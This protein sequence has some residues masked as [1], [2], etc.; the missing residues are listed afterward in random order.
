MQTLYP[1]LLKKQINIEIYHFIEIYQK[2]NKY[3]NRNS[4]KLQTLYPNLSKKQINIEIY[5]HYRNISYTPYKNYFIEIETQINYKYFIQISKKTNKYRNLLLYRNRN[6]DK[7][8]TLYPN[9]PK[10]QINI[11]IY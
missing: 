8:Q 11:E 10:K 7:L 3:R 6:S 2:T 4:D 1:N 5:Q 9:L